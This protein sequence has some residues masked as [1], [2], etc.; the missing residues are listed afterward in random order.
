ML[1]SLTKLALAGTFIFTLASC[2]AN[3]SNM[4][5]T[6]PPMNPVVAEE[7]EGVVANSTHAYKIIEIQGIGDVY[8]K[9]LNDNGVK[10]TDDYLQYTA[11][12]YDRLK[13]SEKTGISPKLL[14]T[15]ANAIDIMKVKGI[16]PKQSNW[17]NAVGVDSIKELAKRRADNL[18]Q[19]LELANNIVPS[20]PFVKKMV[21]QA[22]V[23][24][25]IDSAKSTKPS[26]E[27]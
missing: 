13:F 7:D 22:K 20:K 23:Q 11:K 25:W 1:K 17:L 6:P 18:H 27:E 10:Y 14:L 26:V 15:W 16:G 9:K 12:R 19:R 21:S 4:Q 2:G 8:A 3:T 5:L 24:S